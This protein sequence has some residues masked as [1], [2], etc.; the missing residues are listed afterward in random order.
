MAVDKIIENT[1]DF[2]PKE[3]KWNKNDKRSSP[4]SNL[5]ETITLTYRGWQFSHDLL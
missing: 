3:N 4:D 1:E 2:M 5:T